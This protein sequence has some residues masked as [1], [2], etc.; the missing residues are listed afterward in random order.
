[1]TK[2]KGVKTKNKGVVKVFLFVNGPFGPLIS[3]S[4]MVTH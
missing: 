4:Y 3:Q 2:I 1:M